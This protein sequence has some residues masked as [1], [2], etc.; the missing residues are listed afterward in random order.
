MPRGRKKE[1]DDGISKQ[2][3]YYRR[4]KDEKL[5]NKTLGLGEDVCDGS[6]KSTASIAAL[7]RARETVATKIA[8]LEKAIDVAR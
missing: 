2:L 5:L 3:R 1:Y 8:D 6:T 7:K 4:K